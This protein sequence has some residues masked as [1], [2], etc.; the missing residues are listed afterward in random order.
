M[1]R[2]ETFSL[3]PF[4]CEQ[5]ADERKIEIAGDGTEGG[6]GVG[7]NLLISTILRR[8]LPMKIGPILGRWKCELCSTTTKIGVAVERLGWNL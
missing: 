6:R 3:R 2:P 4:W 1:N 5:N 8:F 7:R